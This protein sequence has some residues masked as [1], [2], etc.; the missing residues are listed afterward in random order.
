MIDLDEVGYAIV[1]NGTSHTSR[2][3]IF[4][5]GDV[6]DKRYRQAITA[7]GMGCMAALDTEK[8]LTEHSHK[9]MAT[10]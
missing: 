10:Q 8:W 1:K 3:G 2:D 6:S 7:A 5:A 9:S 4:A